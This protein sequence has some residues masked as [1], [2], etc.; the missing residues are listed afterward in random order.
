MQTKD[1]IPGHVYASTYVASNRGFQRFAFSDPLRHTAFFVTGTSGYGSRLLITGYWAGQDQTDFSPAEFRRRIA[2]Q[3]ERIV[4]FE[5]LP[6]PLTEEQAEQLT[7]ARRLVRSTS[8]R[9]L[10]VLYPW[11]ENAAKRAE[12][13][14]ENAKS[15]AAVEQ[16]Q[17]RQE[18]LKARQAEAAARIA[19]ALG[20]SDEVHEAAGSTVPAVEISGRKLEL[21]YHTGPNFIETFERLAALLESAAVTA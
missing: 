4:Y 8:L 17:A 14:A 13:E 2:E 11:E 9:P 12:R 7:A 6:K 19:K 1:I 21:A 5:S 3:K 16:Q 18:A 20:L 15:A 10:Q